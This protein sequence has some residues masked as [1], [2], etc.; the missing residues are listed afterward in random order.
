VEKLQNDRKKQTRKSLTRNEECW[1]LLG[2]RR[3]R[4]WRARCA[5][6]SEGDAATV[7]FDANAVL[8][9]EEKRGDVVGFLHTHP[10]TVARP[11]QRDL[12]TTRGW[13]GA[14]GKPLLCLID[15]TDGLRGYRFDHDECMG[16]ELMLIERFPRGQIVGVNHG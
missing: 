3:G 9:R 14:F 12:Q 6:Y 15:G 13:V 5:T 4:V 8:Q 2:Q 10:T 1:V 16:I 7:E 11:S